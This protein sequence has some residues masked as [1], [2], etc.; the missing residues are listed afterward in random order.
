MTREYAWWVAEID[1]GRCKEDTP[2]EPIYGLN[3]ASSLVAHKGGGGLL[4]GGQKMCS[5]PVY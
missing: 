2:S 1:T 3:A 5:H 4:H